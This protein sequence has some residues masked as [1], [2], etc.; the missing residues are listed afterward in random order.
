MNGHTI[1]ALGRR[2]CRRRCWTSPRSH[3]FHLH[4][5]PTWNPRGHRIAFLRRY[6][7]GSPTALCS[8]GFDGGDSTCVAPHGAAIT[9]LLAWTDDETVLA[10]LEIEGA[11]AFGYVRLRDGRFDVVERFASPIGY[12]SASAPESGNKADRPAARGPEFPTVILRWRLPQLG[13]PAGLRDA[14]TS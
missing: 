3:P 7:D 1:R 14:G 9:G 13:P 4:A 5:S 11:G 10:S 6:W 8:V 12:A 2:R